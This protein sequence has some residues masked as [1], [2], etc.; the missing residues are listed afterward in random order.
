MKLREKTAMIRAL[1][2]AADRREQIP[3]YTRAIG[4]AI[5][6]AEKHLRYLADCRGLS[7]QLTAVSQRSGGNWL[8]R[9]GRLNGLGDVQGLLG[10]MCPA[11]GRIWDAIGILSGDPEEAGRRREEFENRYAVAPN[12]ELLWDVAAALEAIDDAVGGLREWTPTRKKQS[13]SVPLH[14]FGE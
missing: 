12:I 2:S 1:S 7:I 9:A 5:D 6:D 10:E 4:Q 13:P 14:N 3:G 11:T 8:E